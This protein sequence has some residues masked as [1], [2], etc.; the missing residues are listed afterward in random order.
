MIEIILKEIETIFIEDDVDFDKSDLTKD[1]RLIG[2]KSQL[3]SMLLVALCLRLEEISEDEGFEFDWTSENAMSKSTSFLRNV[4]TLAEE[5][6]LQK[7]S[8]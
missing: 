3:D 7:D 5:Y 2:G 8:S 1:T 6:L 4:T